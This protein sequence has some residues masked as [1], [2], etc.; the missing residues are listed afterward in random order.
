MPTSVGSQSIETV[1]VPEKKEEKNMPNSNDNQNDNNGYKAALD[2]RRE[3]LAAMPEEMINRRIRLDVSATCTMASTAVQNVVELR[4][5]LVEQFGTVAQQTLDGLETTAL[6]MRQ[7]DIEHE[8]REEGVEL[9]ELHR[10]IVTVHERLL[11]DADALAV[12]GLISR[13][14]IAG[15]R[16]AR[17]YQG[18][19]RGVVG[20]VEV[21]R[22]EWDTIKT[23][24]AVDRAELDAAIE[25]A[26]RFERALAT[27]PQSN[28]RAV[29]LETRTRALSML[30]R[31]YEQLRRMVQ[32]LRYF[33]GDTDQYVPSL[34]A[35][36]RG[37]KAK[38]VD[39]GDGGDDTDVPFTPVSGPV[40]VNGGPAFPLN[41]GPAFPT[42]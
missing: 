41:G 22:D 17:S 32:Y 24:T 35:G 5:E 11:A 34:Y 15:F 29:A 42:T 21:L 26:R 28:G 40:P 30:V 23:R 8:G 20:I 39:A 13:D 12:R 16:D 37:R 1:N 38:D 27:G 25:I 7:A 2:A 31:E 19:L 14:R 10:E 36:R 3:R 4:D 33:E 6:A 18:A 9:A